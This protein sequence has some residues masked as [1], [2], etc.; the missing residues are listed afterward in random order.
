MGE[1]QQGLGALALSRG[2]VTW[3]DLELC[4]AMQVLYGGDLAT[5]LVDAGIT[6][7]LTASILFSDHLG[8]PAGP[9]GRLTEPSPHVSDLLPPRLAALHRVFPVGR[10]QT[11]LEVAV[12][13]PLS[14]RVG[15]RLEEQAGLAV[16][17]VAVLPHRLAEA[18]GFYCDLPVAERDAWLLQ[19]LNAGAPATLA[20]S[21]EGVRVRVERAFPAAAPYR[22]MSEHPEGIVPSARQA[23]P[24]PA[25]A[26]DTLEGFG[27][28][29]DAA[30]SKRSVK[31]LDP[32]Q[33]GHDV[34]SEPPPSADDP[35]RITRPYAETEGEEGEKRDT[36]PWRDDDPDDV[37]PVSVRG[38]FNASLSEAPPSAEARI[39][40]DHRR[41]RHR[42]PFTRPQAEL[43]AT[44]ADDVH[45]VL[46]VLTRYARQFFERSVLFVVTGDV[47]ELR[48]SHGLPMGLATLQLSLVEEPSILRDAYATGDP[49]VRPLVRDG[50]DAILRNKLS[51]SG[52]GRVAVIP[53]TIR[54]RV[55]AIFYGDDRTDGVDRDAVADVTDFIE[56][57]ANEITRIILHKKR[58]STELG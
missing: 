25:P 52:D 18:L 12:C 36:Q 37:A 56:I 13:D 50:V 4:I 7:E 34:A 42:G 40:E 15:R 30:A 57:C 20:A 32:G 11:H 44:Q 38:E 28:D 31:T 35:G 43:A 8:L 49:L 16:R 23:A 14:E 33:S 19:L 24:P 2:L 45:V 9:T 6:D 47:A 29:D 10:T 27:D 48:L 41:F 51:I 58:G 22:R 46:E 39:L 1:T 26:P 21:K 5:T 17:P 53:L 54:E 55:V 3:A